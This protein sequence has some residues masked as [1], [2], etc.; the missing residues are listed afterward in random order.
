MHTA[1]QAFRQVDMV[2]CTHC[3]LLRSK[4]FNGEIWAT[5]THAF[6]G[7]IY[8]VIDLQARIGQAVCAWEGITSY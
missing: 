6:I 1:A 3:Q 8:V 4:E 5:S 7:S 2:D